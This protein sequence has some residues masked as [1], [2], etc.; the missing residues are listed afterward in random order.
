M[1]DAQTP[2]LVVD[3]RLEL[4]VNLVGIA[5][6]AVAT[7]HTGRTGEWLPLMGVSMALALVVL[8]VDSE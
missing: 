6:V 1:A 7:Y 3:Q 4:A 5:A 2:E 8:F